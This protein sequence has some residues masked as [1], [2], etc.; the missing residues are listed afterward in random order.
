MYANVY[1]ISVYVCMN[2]R[3]HDVCVCVCAIRVCVCVC[4]CGCKCKNKYVCN[5][6]CKIEW[7]IDAIMQKKSN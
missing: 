4:V 5:C 7:A 2:A 3:M 6:E 1:A